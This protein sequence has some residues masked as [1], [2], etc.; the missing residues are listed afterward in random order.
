MARKRGPDVLAP[1]SD[2]AATSAS[3]TSAGQPGDSTKQ[4][5]PPSPYKVPFWGH[6]HQ[7]LADGQGTG[8]R[9][10]FGAYL[11]RT[12]LM[13]RLLVAVLEMVFFRWGQCG[14][15]HMLRGC[16]GFFA[17]SLPCLGPCVQPL[18]VASLRVVGYAWKVQFCSISRP[19]ALAAV[20][21]LFH[22]AL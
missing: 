8:G 17:A 11:A 10:E 4:V 3:S 12:L 7:G 19:V 5:L 20:K 21:P 16:P 1:N 6:V 13:P 15:H 9:T 14:H 22:Y 18:G 2:A